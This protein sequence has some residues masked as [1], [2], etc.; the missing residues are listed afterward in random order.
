MT[1][2][3]IL[4]ASDFSRAS[5]RAF[6]LAQESAKAFRAELILFHAYETYV[7][8]MGGGYVSPKMY[9]EMLN[10][11]RTNARRRLQVL[12][13]A[14]RGKRLRVSALL[15]EG[16]AAASIV[17][18]AKGRRVGLVV[19]GTHGR[20]GVTRLLLGSVAERVVRTAPCPVLT[21]RSGRA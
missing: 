19:L 20:T 3:R 13:R 8:P 18:A 17:R 21:V 2:K 9:E 14:A 6:T 12:A 10:A 4:Y 16:P 5:R 7:P 11:T 1:I 15:V